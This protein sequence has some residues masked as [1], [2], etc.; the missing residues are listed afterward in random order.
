MLVADDDELMRFWLK[1]YLEGQGYDVVAV[2]NG[3]EAVRACRE[4]PFAYVFLDLL[5]P[6]TK[7]GAR[8]CCEIK[9]VRPDAKIIIITAFDPSAI[10][11]DCRSAAHAIL[12][13]P[14][15]VNDL[16]AAFAGQGAP[17]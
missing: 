8:S 12:K 7:D 6:G 10:P 2:T 9:K 11:G 4:K 15:G 17:A 16:S 3:E 14:F 13:K 5:M 1:D